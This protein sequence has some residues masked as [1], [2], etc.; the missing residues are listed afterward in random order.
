MEKSEMKADGS[1]ANEKLKEEKPED[2]AKTL[3]QQIAKMATQFENALPNRIGAERMMRIVMTA[4]HNNHKLVQCEPNSF[5]GAV[6]QSLQLGLEVNTPLGHAY[7]IPRWEKNAWGKGKAGYKCNFQMGYQG[8]LELCYRYGKYR[9]I[10]SEVVFQ[11]DDFDFEL[12]TRQFL[13]HNPKSKSEIPTFVWALYEL[14]T[15]GQRFVVWTW[16]KI[17]DHAMRFSESYDEEKEEWTSFSAWSSNVESQWSMGQKT[18][19][20]DLLKYAPK[21]VELTQAIYADNNAIIAK[22]VT[23]GGETR[24]Q[25]DLDTKL[26]EDD[27]D[28]P[29]RIKEKIPAEATNGKGEPDPVPAAKNQPPK[30]QQAASTA[31]NG[32]AA[33]TVNGNGAPKGNALFSENEEEALEEQFKQS[34]GL[35]IF[36]D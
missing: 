22:P 5:F 35:K 19:L 27:R 6:L 33:S 17:M 7:L 16:E 28:N 36:G 34:Q 31:T 15:G 25:F 9:Q 10:T 23:E 29:D 2:P 20:A 1:N 24:L 3:K 4:I 18:V 32:A 11:G 30:Q 14:D 26:L 8:L 21:S 13:R 12:G